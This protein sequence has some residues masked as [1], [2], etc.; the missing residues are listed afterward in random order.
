MTLCRSSAACVAD[1]RRRWSAQPD[2][3]SFLEPLG[4]TF[5]NYVY[6]NE[7]LMFLVPIVL[8][9]LLIVFLLQNSA[10]WRERFQPTW[11]YLAV[12]YVLF[13]VS[14]LDMNKA[15]VFLYYDF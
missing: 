5:G 4:V 12:T 8:L 1:W 13:M 7:S 15:T 10:Q 11:R 2:P 9:G 14:L 6:S 3:F